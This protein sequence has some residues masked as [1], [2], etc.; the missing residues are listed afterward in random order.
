MFEFLKMGTRL[1]GFG[2][3]RRGLRAMY[4]SPIA[5]RATA[6]GERSGT[7]DEGM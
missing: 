4:K 6:R 2:H 5:G 1:V 7:G 3:V